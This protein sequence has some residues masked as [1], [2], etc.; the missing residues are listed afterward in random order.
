MSMKIIN[1]LRI[2]FWFFLLFLALLETPIVVSYGESIFINK[3]VQQTLND[4]FRGDRTFI[5]TWDNST[6]NYWLDMP[7]DFD[8]STLTPLIIFLHGHGGD[9]YSYSTDENYQSLRLAFQTNNWIVGAVDCR[10]IDASY[11]WYTEPSRR[12]ITDVLNA[13]KSE[14]YIDPRHIHIMGTSMG[15]TGALQYAMFNIEVIAS[16]VDIMGIT[17]FTQFYNENSL[18]RTSLEA[19]FGGSPDQVPDIYANESALG[20]EHRFRYLPVMLLHGTD[21]LT[22]SVTH[23]RN[24]N[25]SLTAAECNVNYTEVSGVGHDDESLLN[26]REIE[27]LNWLSTTPFVG[28]TLTVNSYGQGSVTLDPKMPLYVP[29]S[30]VSISATADD[31]WEFSGWSGAVS[32]SD[33][34]AVVTMD[35][36]LSVVA[37]FTELPEPTPSPTPEP[38]PSPSPEPTP[39]PTPE[40]T[41]SPTPE[42]TSSPT[43]EPTPSPSGLPIEAL[44]AIAAFAVAFVVIVAWTF[45]RKRS[46]APN[47]KAKQ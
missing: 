34:P 28:Y 33:N 42:P 43:P 14:Y 5:S 16:A 47:W 45:I 27:I 12:D 6:R 36:N 29:E 17:N 35:G 11:D 46:D 32:G 25:L 3:S 21:D 4:S 20:N 13:I 7:D 22:V 40:P 31:G 30:N 2:L 9:R 15:G 44:Y 1:N 37:T 38:T 23:S 19:A 39:S 8:N 18:F 10:K 26:G 24:L 41:S